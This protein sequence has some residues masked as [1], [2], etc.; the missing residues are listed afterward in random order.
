MSAPTTAEAI[1]IEELSPALR[2]AL[3]GYLLAIADDA[4]L[5]GH[6]DSEW[7]GLGPI[8]EED[9]AFSSMAQDELGHALVLYRLLHEALGYAEPDELAFGR[10]AEAWRHAV[11]QERPRGDYAYSLVRRYLYDLERAIRYDGW[12]QS[13]LRELATAAAKLG[14]EKKYHRMHDQAYVGRL[15]KAGGEAR[16]RIQAALDEALPYAAG[17]WEAPEGET[18]LVEAGLVPPSATMRA[19]WLEAIGRFLGEAG[20]DLPA[21]PPASGEGGRRG[22]HGPELDA[23]LEAMQGMYRSD[24]AAT[25]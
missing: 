4:M 14:Q 16:E 21:I 22:E 11:A 2:E 5:Q 8:L 24:P 6:R 7:T 18:A 23:L 13:P 12:R 10:D 25:W 15:A 17:L 20:L 1:G 19:V 9:I 3:G